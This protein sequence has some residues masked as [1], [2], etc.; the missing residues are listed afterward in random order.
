MPKAK[1]KKIA[2]LPTVQQGETT[3]ELPPASDAQSAF[4]VGDNVH[5]PMFG[6]GTVERIE[7]NKLA[8]KFGGNVT[9]V[10]R[11]DYVTRKR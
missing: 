8:I 2:K 9:K 7:D 4:S 11:E 5:H 10:I 6:D 1:Q 3:A